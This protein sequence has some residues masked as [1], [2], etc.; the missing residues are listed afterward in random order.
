[1]AKSLAC[2]A[3][4]CGMV[5]V[6]VGCGSK[7]PSVPVA[8]A[9]AADTA[10]PLTTAADPAPLASEQ[11]ATRSPA[12]ETTPNGVENQPDAGPLASLTTSPVILP[13]A[14]ESEGNVSGPAML[15]MPAKIEG[16]TY[17]A[18]AQLGVSTTEQL[19]IQT[20]DSKIY[21]VDDADRKFTDLYQQRSRQLNVTAVGTPYLKDGVLHLTASEIQALR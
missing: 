20:N 16:K 19:A 11:T 6:V 14:D 18:K 8:Q 12:T 2:W 17:C 3:L 9:G 13:D 15:G 10:G 4:A 5:A 21:V 1:M 7:E